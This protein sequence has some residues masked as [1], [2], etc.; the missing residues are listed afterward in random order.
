MTTPLT[1]ESAL[2]YVQ[3]SSVM[4]QVFQAGETLKAEQ[5]SEGNV[6]LLFRVYAEGDA[7]KKSVLVKQALPYAWRYPAFKMP[8]DRQRIEYEI[9]SLEAKYCPDQVP[10][11]YLYDEENHILVIEF[12]GRHMVMREGLMMQKRYP[13][14]AEHMG[15]FMARTLFYTSDLYLS[16]AE[17]K[18][19]VPK[20]INPVLCKIQ[21]DLVFT[22][23][24]MEHENNRYSAPL[25]A[26]VQ[27]IYAND[28]L[29]S[30]V[31]ILKDAYMSNAQALLHNDLHTGSIM[32]NEEE[33]K[34]IDPEFGFYGPMGHDIGSYLGNLAMGCAAQEYHAQDAEERAA[35]REWIAD[36]LRATW[37]IFETEFMSLWEN[38]GNGEW[39]SPQYRKD[40]IRRLLGDTAGFGATEMMRRLIGMAHVHDFW[41]IEDEMIRATAES[42]ALNIA[43][44]WLMNRTTFT[45][46]DD[47]VGAVTSAKP[48]I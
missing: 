21:E 45:S 11:I 46:I 30:T 7:E 10:E 20:F 6:N 31:Y 8:V 19:M 13:L 32:L 34:V 39:A 43:Q 38:E 48:G 42:Q 2:E 33:T 26:Q 41:T 5:I 47:L 29:R 40:Y 24:Y 35:Y 36:T 22:Q 28:K 17:K 3:Q 23:P 37:N 18:A 1:T 4:E 25:E 14:V 16:S 15:M 44:D 12:L 27:A 9:I